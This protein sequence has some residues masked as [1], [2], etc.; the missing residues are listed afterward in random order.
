MGS[1]QYSLRWNNYLRHITCAFDSL[2]SDKDLVDVT[3]SCDG[4]K[5][6]AHKMLLSACSSYF[7]DLFKE[8]PCQHPV[9]IFRNVRFED[10]LALIDFMY[11]GEVN[12][13]QEQLASFLNTAELL[14]V[15]GL[16]NSNSEN[17]TMTDDSHTNTEPKLDVPPPE[18]QFEGDDRS[19]RFLREDSPISTKPS[20]SSA[21]AAKRRRTD[22][23]SD[24]GKRSCSPPVEITP[25][26]MEAPDYVEEE[27][28]GDREDT[29]EDTLAR[30]RENDELLLTKSSSNQ[31]LDP[32]SFGT[33]SITHPMD[34]LHT[35]DT[36]ALATAGPSSDGHSQDGLQ[37]S[38]IPGPSP[39]QA[40]NFI[41]RSRSHTGYSCRLCGRTFNHRDSCQKHMAMHLGT[42]KCYV[43]SYVLSRKSHMKRHLKHVHGIDQDSFATHYPDSSPSDASSVLTILR[44]NSRL[45]VCSFCNRE[46]KH[47]VS[48]HQHLALHK[49][50]SKCHICNCVLSRKSHLKRHLKTI[51]GICSSRQYRL[52][53]PSSHKLPPAQLI[54]IRQQK[55]PSLKNLIVSGADDSFMCMVC[56]RAFKDRKSCHRHMSMHLGTSTCPICF[57]ILTTWINGSGGGQQP[58]AVAAATAQTYEKVCSQ[59]GKEFKHYMSLV[60]HRQVHIG[61]TT[62]SICGKVFNRMYDMKKHMKAKHSHQHTD[63]QAVTAMATAVEN[64]KHYFLLTD[65]W[66]PALPQA[67][68]SEVLPPEWC[69]I[70]PSTAPEFVIEH[71]SKKTFR[72]SLCNMEYKSQSSLNCHMHSHTNKSRCPVCGSLLNRIYDL[73]RHLINT[74][75]LEPRPVLSGSKLHLPTASYSSTGDRQ[76]PLCGLIMAPSTSLKRHIISLHSSAGEAHEATCPFCFKVFKNKYTMWSHRSKFH[77]YAE[78]VDLGRVEYRK[79]GDRFQCAS[80]DCSYARL[81]NLS[82]HIAS[83]HI[84]NYN[85]MFMCFTCQRWFK[86]KWSLATHNSRFHRASTDGSG[87]QELDQQQLPNLKCESFDPLQ[88]PTNDVIL[89]M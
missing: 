89:P 18:V 22:G 73:R 29:T 14:Q 3:L 82:R 61:L 11:Q 70:T 52:A 34:I 47:R 25:M 16:T 53:P 2:R 76:C 1:Q 87:L 36:E 19:P 62:C 71:D 31:R 65:G 44:N 9:V 32:H 50:T 69:G 75:K 6:Q 4:Q 12:V 39:S 28:Q 51:H 85:G 66:L 20:T 77:S 15:Q 59:C 60:M 72:C 79:L 84:Q 57:S 81:L 78:D 33:S 5:V 42:S 45:F 54:P 37:G 83:K 68:D 49:G 38:L 27:D 64:L 35:T 46:F 88:N 86:T 67:Q 7:R 74:H 30:L 21:P 80:C 10:L 24:I 43:C 55:T 48:C 8:N 56:G 40:A 63:W 13:E 26:K 17:N 23:G 41:E 58:A